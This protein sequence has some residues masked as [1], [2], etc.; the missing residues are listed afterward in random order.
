MYL[1]IDMIGKFLIL[2]AHKSRQI[3]DGTWNVEPRRTPAATANYRE[4]YCFYNK[5][6]LLHGMAGTHLA[7]QLHSQRGQ[8]RSSKTL[9]AH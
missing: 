5:S 4:Q 1:S 6:A 8:V 7:P 2:V 3:H 9:V